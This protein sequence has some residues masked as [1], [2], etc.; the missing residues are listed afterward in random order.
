MKTKRLRMI[1]ITYTRVGS[2]GLIKKYRNE[3][4]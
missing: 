2:T 1:K 3:K 4:V